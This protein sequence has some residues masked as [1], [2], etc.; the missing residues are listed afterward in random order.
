[1]WFTDFVAPVA[2]TDWNNRQFSQ[3]DGTADSG[4]NFFAALNTETD[5]TVAVTDGNESLETGTLTGTGLF[6]DRH[7][8]QDLILQLGAQ[9]E[10]NDFELLDWQRVQVDLLQWTDFAFTNQTAK[11]GYWNPF[12]LIFLSTATA[13]TGTTTTTSTSATTTLTKRR[14]KKSRSASS[15]ASSFFI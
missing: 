7:D 4:G 11:L 3:D 12:L 10:I 14:E 8:F 13:T 5:V 6:L 2:T 1:M 9:E 15:E